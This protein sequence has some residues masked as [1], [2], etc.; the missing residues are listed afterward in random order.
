[1]SPMPSDCALAQNTYRGFT[2]SLAAM[3]VSVC[4]CVCVCV[5]ARVSPAGA[6][7]AGSSSLV[8]A[9]VP[10]MPPSG[11]TPPF[12]PCCRKEVN[13]VWGCRHGTVP[14]AGQEL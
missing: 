8:T 13:V 11:P 10:E 1:M 12:S 5:C 14:Q 4:V 6:T 9:S 3:C 7:D 2:P